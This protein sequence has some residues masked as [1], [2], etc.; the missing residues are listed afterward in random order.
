[1]KTKLIFPPVWDVKSPFPSLPCLA[2]Y[3]QAHGEDVE[4][5]DLNLQVFDYILSKEYLSSCIDEL[6][7][8]KGGASGFELYE[9]FADN[10][11][12]CK[13]TLRSEK[14][15]D[16]G[17]Y[18]SCTELL[19]HCFLILRQLWKDELLTFG[20]YGIRGYDV[21][22]SSDV[23]RCVA[24][25]MSGKVRSRLCEIL[26][27][28]IDDVVA[29]ADLIGISVAHKYQVIPAFLIAAMCKK[30]KPS[31]K[32]NVGG[33]LVTRW[34]MNKESLT[35]F[36]DVVDY[37]SFFEGEKSL[38]ALV[39]HLKGEKEIGEVPS[40]GYMSGGEVVINPTGESIAMDELPTPLYDKKV[41]GKYFSPVP[42]VTL[43][44]CRGCFW[45]RCAFCDHAIV[46]RDCFRT[47]SVE[48]IV[49]DIETCIREYGTKYIAFNDE[50]ITA[51]MLR[52]L[53]REIIR[54]NIDIRW[55]NDARFD[56]ALDKE[57]FELAYKAGLRL[58]FFGL[59]SYNE[60]VLTLINKG[61]KREWIE[62]IIKASSEAGIWNHIY[63]IVGFPTETAQ[64]FGDTLGF[65]KRNDKYIDSLCITPFG[66]TKF[67]DVGRNP[68]KYNVITTEYEG[69]DLSTDC[70]FTMADDKQEYTAGNFEHLTDG[71][72][73]AGDE[74]I[75]VYSNTVG[76]V[77]SDYILE[78]SKR[79]KNGEKTL[80][81]F[82]T[83][84]YSDSGKAV[85]AA[86]K[87]KS[88]SVRFVKIPKAL[89]P[90]LWVVNSYPFEE[91]T[92]KV[93]GEKFGYPREIS[94][95]LLEQAKNLLK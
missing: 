14:A 10:V 11:E 75:N 43:F 91:D 17:V 79:K 81:G 19:T 33:S 37:F 4:Q 1:M 27:R 49:E 20:A 42:V 71:V 24:D 56:K 87:G 84:L 70:K 89:E 5:V 83:P 6:K 53:S 35:A 61:I 59:E 40:L 51:P 15:L 57:T 44:T 65:V 39:K 9:Y 67:A 8:E 32:I 73:A 31:V 94:S 55:R 60:R 92:Y 63:A 23:M 54:R 30:A 58:L 85:Y 76:V 50:A 45:N 48:R 88:G 93:L 62:P 26:S 22:S 13:D 46:Y 64:E 78:C 34:S 47:R 80:K 7:A 74:F 69:K 18:K 25:V 82:A 41:I 2:G 38:F 16:G 12:G 86:A 72:C 29:D 68:E 95:V 52:K 28:Y 21:Y 66:C 90:V 3:L 77:F 36:F